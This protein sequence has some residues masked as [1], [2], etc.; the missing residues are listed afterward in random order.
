[1][2]LSQLYSDQPDVFEPVR[3]SGG[4]NVILA[5]IRLPQNRDKDTHCL[6]KT[7][8]ANVLDFCLLKGRSKGFFL[9]KH[10]KQFSPFVFYLEIETIT[11]G[12]VTVRRSVAKNTRIA[13]KRHSAPLLALTDLPPTGW[14]HWDLPIEGAQQILDGL[15]DLRA[16]KPWN[17]RMPISYALRSSRSETPC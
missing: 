16:V 11:N 12:Y 3:F 13:I 15:L 4:F 10:E 8:L 1:M 6:G 14:D 5:E 2:R 7:T 9:F 17:Y